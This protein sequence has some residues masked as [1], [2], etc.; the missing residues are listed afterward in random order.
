MYALLRALPITKG[1]LL[2]YR[3]AADPQAQSC[4]SFASVALR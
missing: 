4:V 1:R 2:N 3:Q